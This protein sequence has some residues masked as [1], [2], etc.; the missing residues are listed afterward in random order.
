MWRIIESGSESPEMNM[1]V[2]ESILHSVSKGARPTIRLYAWDQPAVSIGIAQD[3]SIVKGKISIVRRPTGGNAV[4]HH[5]KDFTYSVAA[6]KKLFC[7]DFSTA[8]E[9]ISRCV[10]DAI[11]CV[12]QKKAAIAEKRDI[13]ICKK[14][15][16]GNA[17][18][19]SGKN[20]FL[21]HGAVF[22][23]D[24]SEEIARLFNEKPK[25]AFL[26]GYAKS[27]AEFYSALK[28]SFEKFAGDYCY[29][30]LS[31]EEKKQAKKLAKE[32]YSDP[33]WHAPAKKGTICAGDLK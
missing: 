17:M 11:N 6:P 7:N 33:N 3:A 32:K 22:Y 14:K 24:S 4:F 2:D 30:K 15:V 25:A 21:L 23:N 16:C 18:D 1:A 8:Y 13:V 29:E 9:S 26:S 28:K 31:T 10:L 12:S 5:K 27:S 19:F 20:A